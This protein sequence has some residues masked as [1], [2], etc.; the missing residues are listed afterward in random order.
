MID[1]LGDPTAQ[2]H[3]DNALSVI[4]DRAD[5]YPEDERK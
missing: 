5:V 3:F 4:N 2:Q 1:G